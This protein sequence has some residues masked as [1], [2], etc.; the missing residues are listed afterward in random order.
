MRRLEPR[1]Q[2]QELLAEAELNSLEDQSGSVSLAETEAWV[3]LGWAATEALV[4][5][6]EVEAAVVV[7][8]AVEAVAPTA[9]RAATMALEVA[10]A[11]AIRRWW[12]PVMSLTN[13]ELEP[14]MVKSP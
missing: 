12:S 13:L 14:A 1:A 7:S 2:Q 3:R 5:L 9:F 8:S 4:R 11:R 10:V 6:L